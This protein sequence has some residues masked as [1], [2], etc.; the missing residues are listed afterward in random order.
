MEDA[1]RL[2]KSATLPAM[3]ETRTE[4]IAAHDGG[5]FDGYL[6][7]PS[8]PN[9][10]GIALFQEI[11]GIASYVR[12]VAER[13]ASLGFAVLVPDLYWRIERGVALGG[14][15]EHLASAMSYAGRFDWEDGLK[16]CVAALE[17]LRALPEVTGP[18]GVLGFCLGGTLA[19]LVAAA[20]TPDFAVAYYGSGV[21][22]SLDRLDDIT[23]P[24]LMHFGG[25]DQYIAR[26]KV[27]EVERAVAGRRNIELHVHEEA[28]HAFDNHEADNFY[29]PQ[30]AEDSW[31][32]STDF[33]LNQASRATLKE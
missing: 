29:N 27:A 7:L 9:G 4:R 22:D 18:A 30:A 1:R 21:P 17:H 31:S 3:G 11:F 6:W 14:G 25:S 33:L 12:D 13:T 19:Y 26:D 10:A 28:G 23:C 16:D 20:S 2:G 32:I 8:E 5:S 24:L 15:E